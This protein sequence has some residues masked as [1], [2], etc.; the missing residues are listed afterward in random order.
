M[1]T[2]RGAFS[3]RL[4]APFSPEETER[5][6]AVFGDPGAV[7]RHLLRSNLSEIKARY[8]AQNEQFITGSRPSRAKT[9]LR[10]LRSNVTDLRDALQQLDAETAFWID[11]IKFSDGF[12]HDRIDLNTLTHQLITFSM[13]LDEGIAFVEIEPDK[14]GGRRNPA[15][16]SAVAALGHLYLNITGKMP[17]HT[18]DPDDGNF[19][20]EFDIFVIQVLH[21]LCDKPMCR[22]VDE[23]IRR[24]VRRF[25]NVEHYDVDDEG[26]T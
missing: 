15:I 25:K 24:T 21:H 9:K 13:I 2:E 22:A 17:T 19:T 20:S 26:S 16:D 1:A 12:L 7:D 18:V 6:M 10:A 14:G 4:Q 3:E 5:I 8:I 23:A 11:A